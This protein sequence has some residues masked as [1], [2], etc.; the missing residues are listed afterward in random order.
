M[1]MIKGLLLA[2]IMIPNGA[3][4]EARMFYCDVLGLEEIGRPISFNEGLGLW[5]KVGSY[6]ILVEEGRNESASRGY[7]T[8]EVANIEELMARLKAYN[9]KLNVCERLGDYESF[10]C[11]DPF[12]NQLQFMMCIHTY[13]FVH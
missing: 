8:F 10:R 1:N 13:Q 12:G 4:K 11:H 3:V 5:L 6:P 2:K 9:I 7:F